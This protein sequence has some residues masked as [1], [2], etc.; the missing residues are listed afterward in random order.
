MSTRSQRFSGTV[1]TLTPV[2]ARCR[3]TAGSL[4]L[5]V[6]TSADLHG[7]RENMVAAGDAARHLQIDHAV[8]DVV[9]LDHLAHDRFQRLAR[10]RPGDLELA[11]RAVEAVEMAGHVH[12]EAARHLAHL[13]DA[14]GKLVA[15]ILDMH[16]GDRVPDIA[17]VHIGNAWHRRSPRSIISAVG[18]CG[19]FNWCSRRVSR[20]GVLVLPS[21]FTPERS[22]PL[23]RQVP[24]TN[25][26]DGA[27]PACTVASERSQRRVG[28]QFCWILVPLGLR[29]VSMHID[30]GEIKSSG[31]DW[32]VVSK[33]ADGE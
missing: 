29:C 17:A 24:R 16:C 22:S 6:T 8:D 28:V 15:A 20:H 33:N 21:V 11:E 2:S 5:A 7:G 18:C 25:L 4:R 26:R 31:G 9:A 12:D 23:S 10:H 27:L 14:V 30:V 32:L 3:A 19:W 13:I 1:I